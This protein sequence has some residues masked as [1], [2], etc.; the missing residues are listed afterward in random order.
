MNLSLLLSLFLCFGGKLYAQQE[1]RDSTKV[2]IEYQ[3]DSIT[4]STIVTVID[5]KIYVHAPDKSPLSLI[6]PE[7]IESVKITDKYE[8]IEHYKKLKDLKVI[9]VTLKKEQ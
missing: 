3:C 1:E 9:V 4:H 7:K 8:K 5:N 6:S 2:E